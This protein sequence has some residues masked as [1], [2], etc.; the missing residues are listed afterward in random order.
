[1]RWAW[2]ILLEPASKEVEKNKQ[3]TTKKIQSLTLVGIYQ[4]NI[5]DDWKHCQQ[6]KLKQLSNKINKVELDYNNPK[7]EINTHEGMLL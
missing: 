6:S 2:S 3:I 5:G 4:R 1:M 7:Y